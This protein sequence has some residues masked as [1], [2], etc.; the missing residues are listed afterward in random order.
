MAAI[1]PSNRLPV[2][3]VPSAAAAIR[4]IY[5]RLDIAGSQS[6]TTTADLQK[7]LTALA[8]RVYKLEHP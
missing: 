8:A 1:Q 2:S 5:D 6:A 7:Q 3:D 4:D